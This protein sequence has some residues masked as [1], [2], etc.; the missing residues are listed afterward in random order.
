[1]KLTKQLR[2]ASRGTI[3]VSAA[4]AA[5]LSA[6]KVA[7]VTNFDLSPAGSQSFNVPGTGRLGSSAGN[8]IIADYFQQPTGT[9]VFQPFLSLD[10]NGQ[11]S[12]GTKVLEQ[13]YNSD[14]F[15]ALY[16]DEHRP[17]WNKLVQYGALAKTGGYVCFTLDSN[18]PGSTKN[19]ISIDNIA[20]YTSPAGSAAANT[21]NAAK[22]TGG[23]LNNIDSLG[24]LRWEM[25]TATLSSKGAV[26]G[27]IGQYVTLNSNQENT[28]NNNS[29]GGSGKADLIVYI[30]TSAFAGVAD[31]DYV[32]LYNVNGLSFAADGTVDATTTT[33]A[34]AGFEE[35]SYCVPD[36]GATAILLGL[37]ALGLAAA[38][39]KRTA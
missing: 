23:T 16:L 28:V 32:W 34:Q 27:S 36:G 22:F 6:D 11:T 25:N 3:A 9:G 38:S 10:A 35:W 1:M 33:A 15:A 39:R 29:N 17:Q 5:F 14:G 8:A 19:L 24:T 18:E 30:P 20:V 31:S 26:A 7:A 12:T 21:A 13:A 37:G 4:V 2:R